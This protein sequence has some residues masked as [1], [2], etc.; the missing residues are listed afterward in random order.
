MYTTIK[1]ITEKGFDVIF[2][3]E[4]HHFSTIEEAKNYQSE[5]SHSVLRYWGEIKEEDR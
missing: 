5:H 4:T 3:G 2:K 1:T